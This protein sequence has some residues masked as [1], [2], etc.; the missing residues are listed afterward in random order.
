M[1]NIS[2]TFKG[3]F[4]VHESKYGRHTE[5][6]ETD[7]HAWIKCFTQLYARGILANNENSDSIWVRMEV[8][9]RG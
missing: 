8:N 1:K 3:T 2:I 6:R 9:T 5:N 7:D 4:V